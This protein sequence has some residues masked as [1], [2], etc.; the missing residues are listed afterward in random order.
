MSPRSTAKPEP[1]PVAKRPILRVTRYDLVFA[2]LLAIVLGTLVIVLVLTLLWISNRLPK[3]ELAAAME[4][5]EMPGGSPEGFAGETGLDVDSPGD[6]SEDPSLGEDPLLSELPDEGLPAE[7]SFDAI[8]NSADAAVQSAQQVTQNL[9]VGTVSTGSGGSST[10]SGRKALGL[11]PGKSGFPRE[12]RWFVRFSEG[13]TLGEYSRQLDYFGI[14]LGA[15]LPGGRMIYL[16]DV[17]SDRPKVREATSGADENRLYMTWQGGERRK[18][19]I[20][21]FRKAGA[22]IGGAIVFH[23]YPPQTEAMLARLERDYR[24]RPADQIRRTYFVVRRTGSGFEYA[25]EVTRQTYFTPGSSG[26]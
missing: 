23:F 26:R 16:S 13:G 25:F 2:S 9:E 3:P 8:V 20:A 12:Q 24:N 14:E 21:L 1:N 7:E 22:D 10:G 15:L 5:V 6:I 19:D 11:G 17:N 18:A 4:L